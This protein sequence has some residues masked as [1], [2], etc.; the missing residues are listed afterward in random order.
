MLCVITRI[1]IPAC[2]ARRCTMRQMASGRM[3]S[4]RNAQLAVDAAAQCAEQPTSCSSSG[5]GADCPIEHAFEFRFVPRRHDPLRIARLH[6]EQLGR[7]QHL[8]ATL[9]ARHPDLP[10]Q[11]DQLDR[12]E[13]T[14][15]RLKAELSVTPISSRVPAKA[16]V[17]PAKVRVTARL[18]GPA[19]RAGPGARTGSGC[20]CDGQAAQAGARKRKP[21]TWVSRYR[22]L[23]L[24]ELEQRSQKV[25][26]AGARGRGSLVPQPRCHLNS[27]RCARRRNGGHRS[28]APAQGLNP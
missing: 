6:R 11:L 22:G 3:L 16:K 12:D 5:R 1:S 17:D 7:C 4:R 21:R 9:L 23:A 28:T 13:Q 18:R 8:R 2:F 19:G 26:V 27:A 15:A 20:A 24:S 10:G 25:V 14:R